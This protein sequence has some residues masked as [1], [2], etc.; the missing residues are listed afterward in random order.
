M[1]QNVFTDALKRL[2]AA[3]KFESVHAETLERL[4][5]PKLFLEVN[6]PVRMD[7]GSLKIFKGFR[8]RYDDTRGPAKGG[9]RFHQDVDPAEVKAPV[10]DWKVKDPLGGK[11]Q[12]YRDTANQI[13]NLVMQLIIELR[14]LRKQWATEFDTRGQRHAK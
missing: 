13:E 5:E 4:K 6:I 7:D 11:E 3:S 9:I 12:L 14:G 8:C 10:R 2:E 1:A